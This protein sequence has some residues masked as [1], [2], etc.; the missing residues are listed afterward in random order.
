VLETELQGKVVLLTGA[1][2]PY[3]VGAGVARAFA[4]QG[5]R[6]YLHYFRQDHTTTADAP[7]SP[8]ESFYYSQQ[9]KSAGEVLE[10]VHKLGGQAC[11]FEADLSDP[12]SVPTLFDRA[13][14][15]L[16]PV[17]TRSAVNPASAI[18][19]LYPGAFWRPLR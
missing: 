2:N 6:V 14:A 13:E 16:G 4:T 5:A 15:N 12:A 11:A 19:R 18:S 3:G 9:S 10:S 17:Y 8:G 1:N 7:A